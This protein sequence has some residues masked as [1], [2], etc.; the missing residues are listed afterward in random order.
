MPP[1][2]WMGSLVAVGVGLGTPVSSLKMVSCQPGGDCNAGIGGGNFC[3][4][5]WALFQST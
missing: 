1:D 2:G 5:F 4:V 3:K